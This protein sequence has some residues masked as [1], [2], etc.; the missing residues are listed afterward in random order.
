MSRD[1][2]IA[3]NPIADFVR[4]RGYELKPAGDNFVT[5]GCPV[6]QHKNGHRP[7][8]IYPR[9]QSWS[10]HDCKRG[11]SV[12]DWA[13][14]EKGVDA[15]EAMRLLDGGTNGS[16]LITTYDYTNGTGELVYQ[17]CRYDPKDFRQRRPDGKGRWIWNVRGVQRVLY[18]LPEIIKASTVCVTEGEKDA[19]NLAA[20]G[21]MATT[22]VGGAGKWRDE[23]S[24]TLRNR[25]VIILGDA[26]ETGRAHVAQVVRSLRGKACSIKVVTLPDEC[27]D[28]SD[29]IESLPKGAAAKAID[30][31]IQAAPDYVDVD[32]QSTCEISGP[33]ELPPPPAPYQPPPLDLLPSELQDYVHDAAESINVDVAFIL[34]PVL[35]SLG[36]AIGN[37]RSILLK[38]GFTQPP[39]I[40]TGTIGPSGSRKSPSLDL[41]CLAVM[42]HER[43]LMQQNKEAAEIYADELAQWESERRKNGGSKPEEPS[44]C[45]GTCDDLTIEVLADILMANPRGVLVRKD[46]LSHWL[47]SFDQYKN[48]RG[49]DVSRWLTLH[50]AAPLAV[51]RRT[52]HRHYRIFNPRVSLTGGIQPKIL[53]RVLTP[54]F[55]ERGLPARFVFAY[56]RFRQDKW[57]E[58]TVSEKRQAQVLELFAELWLLQPESDGRPVLLRLSPDAKAVF[59]EFYNECGE[60]ALEAS[61]HEE[62]AWGKLT[63]YGAR[64]ALV[65]QLAHDQRAEVVTG[66]VM[67][68][69]CDLARWSGRESARIYDVL[70]ETQE[71]REQ[72]E[73][74][75]FIERRDGCVTTRDA[76]QNYWPLRNDRDEA[77]RQL[78]ALVKKGFGK[79]EDSRSAGRGRPTRRFRLLRTSTSTEMANSRGKSAN[80]VDVDAPS[81]QEN[82]RPEVL[83]L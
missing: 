70:A 10:C 20:L 82:T 37:S 73:L 13:V 21:F 40:W 39:I 76:M 54:E 44:F 11:G 30:E 74:V 12:I 77:E 32:A 6:T 78:T 68:V 3:A 47:A 5:S 1:E 17:A 42:E 23:Y 41:G 69:A 43:E 53:W 8:T 71:Q 67:Q 48:A 56:P 64:F 80:C 9:T 72:R 16:T 57:S 46:E 33:S 79:W 34:L 65:S 66:A 19:D 50:T 58:A 51:D 15:A 7:V 49:S 31:L 45:T 81:R 55:F 62:A 18:R 60:A 22:N 35:S 29:Y 14:F 75:D 63:G 59:I 25:D 38:R 26:D 61:E 27:H 83:E 28:I 24:E 2:I 4:K 36:T 52:D